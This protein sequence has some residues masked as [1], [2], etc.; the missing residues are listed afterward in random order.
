M[1]SPSTSWKEATDTTVGD[2]TKFGA[3]DGLNK[4]NQLFN[5]DLNVDNVDINSPWFFR[6]QKCYFLNT[7]GTF[8]FLIGS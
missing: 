1:T 6:T 7:A 2:A 4:N 5:G 3:P 8:G